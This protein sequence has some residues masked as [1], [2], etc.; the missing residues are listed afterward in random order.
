MTDE[1]DD[2]I[3]ENTKMTF[4]EH[5]DEL[6]LALIKSVLAL[7]I[8]F[9]VALLFAGWV[10]DY[11]QTPLKAALED[12][13]RG[14]AAKSYLQYLEQ[15]RLEGAPVPRDIGA[16]AQLMA[17]EGLVPDERLIDPREALESIEKAFPDAID[18]TRLPP[19]DP[20]APINRS[21]LVPLRMYHNL[22]DDPRVRVVGLSVQEPFAV[23]IKAAAV[24][25]IVLSSPLVFFFLWQFVGAGLY[26]HEKQYV[27]VFLPIS[28]GLF[29]AGVMLAFFFVFR[30]VLAFLFQFYDWM[31]IDPDPRITDWLTFVLIL[32]LGFG[33]SF[34]LPLVMLFLERIGIFSV[35][36]YMSQWRIAVLVIFVLAM[37][38]TPSD[39]YSMLLM[40]IP[41]TVLYFGG[42]LMCRLMPRRGPAFERHGD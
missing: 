36:S 17:D 25:G 6:R 14:L 24:L 32:P 41:L 37:V 40:A 16:A 2:G 20:T 28:L 13:Y 5:L 39:P 23:Y 29:L 21:E 31:G 1:I 30:F 33:I 3:F 38:L 22:A 11:V 34:Q 27:R 4:G 15:R 42:V 26:P 7:S 9:L 12:Y 8:G 10:V 18:S 35:K 19:R